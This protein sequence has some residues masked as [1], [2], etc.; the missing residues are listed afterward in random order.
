MCPQFKVMTTLA[1]AR[2]RSKRRVED[3]GISHL[4]VGVTDIDVFLELY[5]ALFFNYM[6]SGPGDY[7]Y[8]VGF[9]NLLKKNKWGIAAG[10]ASVRFRRRIPPFRRFSLSTRV[11]CLDGRWFCFLRET[12]RNNKICS[13]A[14]MKIGIRSTDGLVPAPDVAQA[15]D[16]GNWTPE[17]PGLG[18]RLGGSREPATVA[19]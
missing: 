10:G 19:L 17:I 11:I 3:M 4:I 2:F 13:S 18:Y 12:H 15:M 5:N 8:R 14:L 16:M 1:K 9:L 6:E 7:G